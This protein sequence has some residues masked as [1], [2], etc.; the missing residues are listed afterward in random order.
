MDPVHDTRECFRA[1]VDAMSQPGTVAESPMEPADHAVL[2]T[3][4]DHEVSCFTPDET[5]RT[6]LE[7]E[8]R[9]A[10]AESE[11]ASIVHAPDPALCPVGDLTTGS[12]KEPGDAATVVYC[13]EG[14]VQEPETV[15]TETTLILSGPGVPGQRR[16]GIDGFAPTDA[17]ALA[18]AQSSYPQGV[19]AV[20]TT[21]LAI[22]A[23]P[24]SVDLE[25]A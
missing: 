20:L 15:Q 7:N 6:A 21:D 13:V 2:A 1:L 23:L 8:G 11:R 22:A 19:D 24:R 18:D 17:Q 3:L 12:L 10:D 5:I 14:L 9:L 25:V 4:V 16:L